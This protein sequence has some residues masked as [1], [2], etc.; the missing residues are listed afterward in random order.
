LTACRTPRVRGRPVAKL[1]PTQHNTRYEHKTRS[2]T[3]HSP[4]PRDGIAAILPCFKGP[5]TVHSLIMFAA[6]Y[7]LSLCLLH[8]S[9]PSV[10]FCLLSAPPPQHLL[11]S[12]PQ[13]I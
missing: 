6:V 5:K 4:T 8:K 9:S 3:A 2:D 11:R 7:K 12:R 1:L 10:R 13:F